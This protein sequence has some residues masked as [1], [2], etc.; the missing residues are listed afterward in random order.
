MKNSKKMI[1][2]HTKE[3]PTTLL[4][5]WTFTLIL[6]LSA[7]NFAHAQTQYN[8]ESGSEAYTAEIKEINPQLTDGDVSGEAIFIIADGKLSI[9][10]AVKGVAPSM[11][12]LQHIHG[13]IAGGPGTFPPA[14]ADTNN[15]G[16]I[17]LMETHK[18]TGK[19]LIPFNGAPI[20]L[21]IKSDSYPVANKDGL[22]TYQITI[23]LD[24]LKAAIKEQYGIDKLA[25]EDR[26]IFIH[27]IPEENTLPD[28]VESLPG[29]PAY[30]TVPIACGVIK[31]L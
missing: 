21:E 5:S 18:Y 19:T 4:K 30:I 8:A 2:P 6:A 12:H 9:T 26:V 13:F 31:T 7:V 22:L 15:D 27:G 14:T 24:K 23:P 25:L 11:M 29:V 20:E 16:N 10:L 1:G 17:D 3:K 28:S